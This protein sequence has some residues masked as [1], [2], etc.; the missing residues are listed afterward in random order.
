MKDSPTDHPQ[1]PHGFAHLM[2]GTGICLATMGLFLAFRSSLPTRVPLQLRLDG[3]MGNFIPRDLFV[4]G[5]PLAFAAANL[6]FGK[7][8]LVPS[9]EN[10]VRTGVLRFYLVPIIVVALS[11]LTRVWSLR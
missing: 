4:F 2:I 9:G 10:S 8:L 7:Q 6:F 1:L 5:L 3:T 11:V